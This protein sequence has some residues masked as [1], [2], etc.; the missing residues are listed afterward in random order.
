M[1]I[2]VIIASYNS[3]T[4]IK[5]C[6]DSLKNQMT[7]V[8]FEVIVV[9]SSTDETPQIIKDLFPDVTLVR[10]NKRTFQGPA[11]NIGIQRAKADILAFMDADCVAPSDWLSNIIK[12]HESP[13]RVICGSVQNGHSES[14]VSWAE[15]FLA[16]SEYLK[17]AP[18]RCV[19]VAPGCN[20]SCKRSIFEECGFFPDIYRLEDMIFSQK[21]LENGHEIL[22][23]PS[24]C[25]YHLYRTRLKD[26]LSREVLSGRILRR[27][28]KQQKMKGSVLYKNRFFSLAFP[29]IKTY[30]PFI[31]TLRWDRTLL[32]RFFRA[33]PFLFIT[34][35]GTTFGLIIAS[36]SRDSI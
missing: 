13:F 19:K 12:A 18:R 11:R 30:L 9:D 15:F 33:V 23:E 34:L 36:R 29:L 20:M 26:L 16:A 1:L 22:F 10:L 8:E 17:N 2:S 7:D 24:I 28:S 27:I 6:L 5:R 35:S 14:L 25:I 21:V 3:R 31:R 4:T 32:P